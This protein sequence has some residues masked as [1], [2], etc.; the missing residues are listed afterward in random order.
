MVELLAPAGK[1]DSLIAAV[2]NGADAVYMSGGKFGARA[3]A[4]N[5]S[6]EELLWAVDYCRLNKVKSYITVNTLVPDRELEELSR[7]LSYINQIGVDAAI[8]QDLGVAA[9]AA[10][11]VPGLCLHASTQAFVTD[12]GGVEYFKNLGFSRVDR[13]SVV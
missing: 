2:E 3:F 11:T 8:V 5:F 1:R 12:A 6:D 10:K 9:V 13:K 7:F 4:P